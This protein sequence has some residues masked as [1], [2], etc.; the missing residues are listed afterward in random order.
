MVAVVVASSSG[1]HLQQHHRARH[2]RGWRAYRQASDQLA[3][4]GSND[5]LL[6]CAVISLN[7]DHVDSS[8]GLKV[9][10]AR[11]SPVS[12]RSKLTGHHT[13]RRHT[14]SIC[15]LRLKCGSFWS[16]VVT[17]WDYFEAGRIV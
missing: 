2:Q 9:S 4:F 5:R 1:A 6:G 11:A 15:E 13:G 8:E 16:L 17:E 10:R 3:A 7:Y 14:P 12:L